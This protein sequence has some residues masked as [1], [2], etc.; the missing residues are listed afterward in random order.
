MIL[1][2]GSQSAAVTIP[3]QLLSYNS[4]DLYAKENGY[5]KTLYA[6]IGTRVRKGQLLVVLEAPE[7]LSQYRQA[8]ADMDTRLAT[9]KGS[10]ANYDRL[11]RTS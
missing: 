5:V 4:V 2:T 3:G 8:Q 7:L 9:Y 1:A 10:R 11:Y 6:D